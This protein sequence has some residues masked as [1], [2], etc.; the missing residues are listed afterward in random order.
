MTLPI[1]SAAFVDGS[2]LSSDDFDGLLA[3]GPLDRPIDVT[4]FPSDKASSQSRKRISLRDLAA[5][6]NDYIAPSKSAL[7]LI[8][9]ATFGEKITPAGCYRS[10]ANM[11]A[12]DGVEG[13]Y[14]G[15][16][17]SLEDAADR[18]RT[19]NIAGVIFESPSSTA[20]APR[21]RVLCPL[22]VTAVAHARN[23]LCARLNGALGGILAPE[24]FRPSQ[25][26]YFGMIERSAPRRV[27]ITEGRALDAANDLDAIAIY[28]RAEKTE[29]A[30]GKR[31][32][33]DVP[34]RVFAP[35]ELERLLSYVSLDYLD[36]QW[37]WIQ[38]GMAL[39]HQFK[40]SE[41][42]LELWL[43]HSKR[44]TG[45]D[46]A[47]ICSMPK[48]WS[49]WSRGR[50]GSLTTIS[51]IEMWAREAGYEPETHP[52]EF[53][54]LEPLPS[55][56]ADDDFDSLLQLPTPPSWVAD[57]NKRHAVAFVEGKCVIL[58]HKPDGATSYGSVTDLNNFY[59]N[60]RRPTKNTSEP[61]TRAWMRHSARASYPNGI[62]FQPN[63]NPEG[64]FN[65][66]SGFSVEPDPTKSCRRFLAHLRSTICGDNDVA[67]QW[68][69]RWFAHMIQRPEEKPGTAVVLKGSKGVGKDTVGDYVG[70]LF[71]RHHTKIANAEHLVGRF[72]AHHQKTLLLHVEEGF[73]AGD[74]KAEGSLK[75]IIT[76]P[77][78]QIEP[79][80][81]DA[82]Q[83][84]SVLRVFVSSN[85][86]WVVPASFDERRFFV[87]NITGKKREPAY[88]EALHRE[89]LAGGRA[90]LLHHLQHLDLSDFDVRNPPMTEGL[91]DQKLE[92]LRSVDRWWYEVLAAGDLPCPPANAFDDGNAC[93]W[94]TATLFDR[95]PLR[96]RYSAWAKD[97]RADGDRSATL[98]LE[99]NWRNL[100]HRTKIAG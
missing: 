45:F 66:W 7:P 10:N 31:S 82:F 87:L 19:A 39:H 17:V 52:D 98:R 22:T 88:F 25:S 27:V 67:Y 18:L 90:A 28:E 96:A 99:K 30:A 95:T 15:E 84:P 94:S 86:A 69:I 62:T 68:L 47:A 65:L 83:V 44:S 75:Y 57:L 81:I 14:D 53:D 35:G 48:R 70:G 49:G 13:D 46:R 100:S 8:K 56:T 1:P 92:S 36:D 32:N 78:V 54:D 33:A 80:G 59:D 71:P 37:R 63:R 16:L 12:I 29:T 9:L 55:D 50:E 79:K 26:Y 40:G 6:V 23:A 21:W 74:H 11:I 2:W 41:E 3:Y 89:M 93:D 61:I 85:E 60:R 5:I 73:W 58:T 51:T 72:N 34:P 43:E 77:Q 64:A 91:R 24:S 4:V 97:Q 20:A 76:S 42:G 38:L